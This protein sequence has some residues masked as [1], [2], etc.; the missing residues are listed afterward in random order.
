[1]FFS[2]VLSVAERFSWEC[3][4]EC[5]Y[6]RAVVCKPKHGTSAATQ[7]PLLSLGNLSK[8]LRFLIEGRRVTFFCA[9]SLS[10]PFGF[11]TPRPGEFT[12]PKTRTW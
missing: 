7:R 11:V 1:M 10:L 9:F 5:V 3:Q 8:T 12:Q 2:R 6:C 4:S